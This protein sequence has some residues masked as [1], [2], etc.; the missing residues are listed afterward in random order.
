MGVDASQEG[1]K[2]VAGEGPV[3]W[4]GGGVEAVLEVQY[5]LG[6]GVEVGEVAGAGR[7]A[8]QAG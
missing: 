2:V 4:F 1:V 5:P 7:L 6:Q 3:E 8:L